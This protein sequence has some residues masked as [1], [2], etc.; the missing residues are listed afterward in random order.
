VRKGGKLG[1]LA[2]GKKL[3]ELVLYVNQELQK[4]ALWFKAN[5]M[6]VNTA[7]TKF[8]IFR[9]HGKNINN[10]ECTLLFN[11]NEPGHPENPNLISQIDRIHNEGPETIFKLL[12]ILFD[13]YL[14]FNAH[15]SHVCSKI[16]KSLFCINKIKNFVNKNA[17][18][19]LYYA[20]V[21]SHLS[22]CI[23]IYSCAN[24]TNLHKLRVKQKERSN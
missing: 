6:A 17:L 8:I 4:I 5:K 2:K 13:E 21:H 11:N 9:T 10:A 19:L 23:N 20:M 24:T 22:Y 16:S 14:S 15:I 3:N 7:K 18:K 12:G 1:C